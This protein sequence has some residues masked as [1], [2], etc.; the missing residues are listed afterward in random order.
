MVEVL[1]N[2]ALVL[3][4]FKKWNEVIEDCNL[5]LSQ[6][7]HNYGNDALNIRG[8]AYHM[9]CKFEEALLDFTTII[10][11]EHVDRRVQVF[12]QSEF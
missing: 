5:I 9:I 10:K 1:L 7:Q 11:A 6:T 8:V 3:S 4:H 12:F 2:R